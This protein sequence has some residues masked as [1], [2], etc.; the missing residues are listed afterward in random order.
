MASWIEEKRGKRGT[1]GEKGESRWSSSSFI[2]ESW[3]HWGWKRPLRSPTPTPTHPTML[4]DHVPQWGDIS[5]A[6]EHLQGWR[7][8]H[9]SGQPV[10]MHHHSFWEEIFS[11]YPT[12]YPTCSFCYHNTFCPFWTSTNILNFHQPS[13]HFTESQNI[14]CWKG[15][16]RITESNP[17]LH[18]EPPQ[19]QT[20]CLRG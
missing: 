9:H 4:T 17:G 3:N 1:A 7:L 14:P 12:W 15:P 5:V 20:L 8:H 11:R 13:E 10:P 16:R 6:L 19:T 18:T 2:T